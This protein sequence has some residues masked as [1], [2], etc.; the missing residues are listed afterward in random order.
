VRSSPR[1]R[2]TPELVPEDSERLGS[3]LRHLLDALPDG[4]RGLTG[5]IAAPLAKAPAYS[6][7]AKDAGY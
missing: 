5:E 7:V 4:G 6:L 2:P 3:A 1:A